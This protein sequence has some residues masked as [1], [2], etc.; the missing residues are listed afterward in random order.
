MADRKINLL[1]SLLAC[2]GAIEAGALVVC[3]GIVIVNSGLFAI[4]Q[5]IS[6]WVIAQPAILPIALLSAPLG[7]LLRMILGL[8]CKKSRF[9]ALVTG[10]IIGTIGSVLFAYST[11]DG[12]SAWLSILP[13]GSIAG[14]VGGWTWWRIEKRFLDRHQS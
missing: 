11:K 5:G 8:A 7:A 13:I 10:T 1:L 4:L 14:L 6:I 2:F 3:I 12:S 9:S